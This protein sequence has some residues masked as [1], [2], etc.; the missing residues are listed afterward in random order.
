MNMAAPDRAPMPAEV[1]AA[2]LQARLIGLLY[3]V[4]AVL[5][6]FAEFYVRGGMIVAHDAA[7]TASNILANQQLYREAGAADIIVLVCDVAVAILF[8]ALLKSVNRTVALL[9]AAFRIALVAVNGAAVLTHFAPLALLA[10]DQGM[11]GLSTAQ[12]QALALLSLK[13]H[14]TA[15]SVAIVFFGI[16]CVLVGY[17]LY[18]SRFVPRIFGVL[19]VLAGTVYVIHSLLE[20]VAVHLPGSFADILLL[21]AGL[22]ELSLAPWLLI[23]AVDPIK[24]QARVAASRGV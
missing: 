16:H 17:L 13:L 8:Y 9:S 18:G 12:A 19:W 10:G 7:K 1:A 23:A 14:S 4:I 6:A 15:F 3:V 24:W 11:S 2:R 20:L 21:I 5:A 22:S